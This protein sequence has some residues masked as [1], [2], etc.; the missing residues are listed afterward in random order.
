MTEVPAGTW[1][2]PSC[3]PSAV[4]YVKQL[5]KKQATQPLVPEVE[6]TDEAPTS[7]TTK[8]AS[9]SVMGTKKKEVAKKGVAVKKPAE[10]KPK[11][12]WVGWVELSSDGEEDF[13]NKVDAQWSVEDDVVGKR[14][15]SSKAVAEENEP[16][17][18]G[19]R[20]RS[21]PQ[22]RVSEQ[23]HDEE[24]DEDEGIVEEVDSEESIYQEKESTFLNGREESEEFL[25]QEDEEE[26]PPRTKS[27]V[28]YISTYDSEDSEDIMEVAQ[29]PNNTDNPTSV[30]TPPESAPANKSTGTSG[31]SPI[32]E[33]SVSAIQDQD[34]MDDDTHNDVEELLTAPIV[35]FAT[36]YKR[37]GNCW[38]EFPES[39]VRSTLPR[40]A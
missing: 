23:V 40:L 25:D 11:P 30:S 20:T 12:K 1:L 32:L 4:F 17:S 37:Q 38:G 27:S 7:K 19:L 5:V 31:V 36:I 6:K 21:K 18:R 22:Q 33:A 28:I 29:R 24:N 39:A 16:S 2:C 3:S 9:K 8:Q 35:D 15:R 10:K 13:N 34:A 14:R 26:A